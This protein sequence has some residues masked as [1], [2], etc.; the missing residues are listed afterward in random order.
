MPGR[1]HHRCGF[2]LMTYAN[3]LDPTC[4]CYPC[5]SSSDSSQSSGSSSSSPG[6]SSPSS[7]S[8]SPSSS[9]SSPASSSDPSSSAGSAGSSSDGSSA[10]SSA[11][12]SSSAG[13]ASSSSGGYIV[14]VVDCEYC[15]FQW[16]GSAWQP[17]SGDLNC[18]SIPGL[19]EDI[20]CIC[21]EPTTPGTFVGE[22]TQISCAQS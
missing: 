7:S 11:G 13:S 22:L 1:L 10:G 17:L 16:D 12:S 14:P 15:V 18:G 2:L 5:D 21:E 3:L 19:L 8:S 6:S 4:T 20:D 9:S